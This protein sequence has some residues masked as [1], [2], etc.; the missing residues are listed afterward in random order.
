MLLLNLKGGEYMEVKDMTKGNELKL[1]ILFSLPLML[2]NIFQQ[3]YTVCDTI[4]VSRHL[5]VKA[6]AAIGCSDW[7]TWMGIAVVTGLAQGFSIPIAHAFG[8]HDKNNVQKC[9]SALVV[10]AIASTLI[11]L[12][13]IYPLLPNILILLKTPVDI[14]DRALAYTHV[15]YLGLFATMFYNALASIL[16]AF[17]NSK[18]PLHAMM[19]AS[20]CNVGLDILF[21]IGLEWG[22]IG[23]GVATVIAQILAGGFCLYHVLKLKEYM[24]D[25]IC[26]DLSYYKNQFRLGIP[27]AL[28]NVLIAIGG[29][30]LTSAVN[31]Y[32]TYFLAGFTAMNKLYGVLEISAVSYGYAMVTYTGQNYGADRYDR[33]KS[34]VKKV[35]LL[36]IGTA[37][38]ISI[39]LW[40]FGP[41]FLSC[42]ISKTS[43]GAT[44]AMTYGL[45]F[46]RC[47]TTFLPI[48]YLLHAYRSTIQGLSNAMIPMV[49]GLFELFMRISGALILPVFFGKAGLYPVEVLAW[50]G[51][52]IILIPSYY[53]MEKK[54]QK[55]SENN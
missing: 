43:E 27:M 54:F 34:G 13:V 25:S 35:V 26:K 33:I 6:L 17:G 44:Q 29:M 1:I 42:F 45:T 37:I 7:L 8:T 21:V 18:T 11:L 31:R 40:I 16:R 9:I 53:W 48:L 14:M 2:G 15:I 3:L 28:Q 50:V 52:V 51:A 22:I 24:P 41:F 38:L 12:V 23:A 5:G 20:V 10:N 32:G 55:V 47:L 39:I 19:I 4:I 46:L 30:V 49:S 36:S